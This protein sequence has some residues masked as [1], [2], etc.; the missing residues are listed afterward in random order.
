MAK[1]N[2][3]Q[4]F[5]GASERE[6]KRKLARY[7]Q[8]ASWCVVA[9]IAIGVLLF[10]GQFVTRIWIKPPVT[11]ERTQG[12]LLVKKGERIQLTVLN[13]S[14]QS[15]VARKFTDFL[16]ARK[17]DVVEMGN[18]SANDVEHSFVIDKIGDTL[19]AQKVAYALGIESAKVVREIDSNAFLDAAVVIG[20]D[21]L[22]LKPMN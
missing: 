19:S 2:L 16:R 4:K 17:F 15:S 3:W 13:G 9:V 8:I 21:Y 14:G 20:K 1:K 5:V 18:Y 10:A 7:M 11:S 12:N 6:R 22:A